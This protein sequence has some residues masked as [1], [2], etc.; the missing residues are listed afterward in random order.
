MEHHA[1]FF[2]RGPAGPVLWRVVIGELPQVLLAIEAAPLV[3][4]AELQYCELY[5][6][7]PGERRDVVRV[8]PV[9][10][11]NALDCLAG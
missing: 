8:S 7:K 4:P 1:R 9:T 6:P 10:L 5:T 11:K 3:A 2:V